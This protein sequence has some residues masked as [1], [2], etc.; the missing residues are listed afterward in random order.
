MKVT[1]RAGEKIPI[2]GTY[3]NVTIEAEVTK[4]YADVT[5]PDPQTCLREVADMVEF[6]VSNEREELL[7]S[8][9]AK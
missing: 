8:I 3:G 5:N 4:E 7:A 1:V 6:F 2:P 9:Q